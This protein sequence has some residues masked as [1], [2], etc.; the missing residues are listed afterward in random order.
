MAA[1]APNAMYFT[2]STMD[3]C[4]DRTARDENANRAVNPIN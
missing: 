4:A 2:M 3:R 1:A